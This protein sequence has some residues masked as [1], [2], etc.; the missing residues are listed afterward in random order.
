MLK[1]LNEVM[2]LVKIIVVICEEA[3]SIS[4][5]LKKGLLVCKQNEV[6]RFGLMVWR[7]R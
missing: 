3:P 2:Q 4:S 1:E 6:L 5:L 7:R